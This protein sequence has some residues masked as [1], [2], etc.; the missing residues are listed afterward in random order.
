MRTRKGLQG[1][2]LIELCFA[3]AIVAVLVGMAVPGFRSGQ[4]SAAIRTA[5][6]ELLAGLQQTRAS[7]ILHAQPADFCPS[8]ADGNCLA[9]YTPS[10]YWR[11]AFQ[12]GSGQPPPVRHALPDGVMVRASRSPLRFWPDAQSASTGTLTICDTH[13]IAAPRAI[14]LSL[15]G[16]PRLA[17]ATSGNCR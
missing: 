14:V 12:A 4:R 9:S 1:V 2:T 11:A 3:L 7:A 8:D 6:F 5:T 16:R 10:T 15:S 13:G 17:S